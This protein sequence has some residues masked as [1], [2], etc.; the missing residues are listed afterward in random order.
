MLPL[1]LPLALSGASFLGGLF[2]NHRSQTTTNPIDPAYS[3]I[4]SALIPMIQKR[5]ANS[6]DLSGLR[7][8]NVSAINQDYAAGEKALTNRLTARG[9]GSSPV[10]GAGI[11]SLQRARVGSI[12]SMDQKLPLI[13]DQMQQDALQQALVAINASRPQKVEGNIGGGAGGALGGLGGMLGFLYGQGAFGRTPVPTGRVG[14]NVLD[15]LG[16]GYQ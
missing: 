3:G 14:S 5:L 10:A 11:A 4:Q 8:G 13:Q 9:L 15:Y 7:A 16:A 1:L 2:G 12:A 6:A